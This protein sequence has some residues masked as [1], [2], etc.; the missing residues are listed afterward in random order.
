[1]KQ[2]QFQY[3]NLHQ[4]RSELRKIQQWRA[5]RITS[6][7]SIQVFSEKLDHQMVDEICG[8]ISDTIP[9]AQYMGCSTNG[10]ICN[11]E[12]SKAPVSIACTVY[13]FP[14]TRIEVLQYPLSDETAKEAA[15]DLCQ[16]V[17]K[18]PWVKAVEM[19]VTIRGMSMTVLCE[20]L[21][22]MRGDVAIFGGGA[23]ADDLDEQAACVFSS[24]G[25]YSEHGVTFLLIGG[26]DFFVETT[27]VAGWKPLGRTFRVT[28]ASR[29]VLYEL[30]GSPAYEVYYN[31]LNI[32]NDSHFFI[33]SLEFPFFCEHNGIQILRAPTASGPDGSLT[34]TSDI[35]EGVCANLAY[36]DPWTILEEIR[37]SCGSIS[38][39]SPEVIHLYSCAARR[40]FW[41]NAEI[42]R[43]S[44]PFQNL[45]STAGFYTSGEFL[46]TNGKMN[47][48]NVTL[49][50][51][52]MREGE[53]A[54][55][56]NDT[57]V[58]S[59]KNDYSGKVSMINRLATFIGA[60]TRELEEANERL[61]LAAITDG[62]TQLLNRAEIQRRITERLE[63]GEQLSLIMLDLDNFKRVNDTYGHQ[64][65]DRVILGLADLLRASVAKYPEASAGRWGGE[66]FMLMLPWAVDSAEKAA[67]CLHTKFRELEFPAAGHQTLSLGVTQ[68]RAEDSSDDLLVRVDK[69]LY[70]AKET[71]KDRYVIL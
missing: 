17:A 20:E 57:A 27:Y 11:G 38:Q 12:I 70:E 49:V 13:E 30:D 10:S 52:A 54:E 68:A 24:A 25:A 6:C 65:G 48:H 46:R 60:A 42:S 63:S 8:V 14:T 56:P 53:A 1:M 18:N 64:E 26:S 59:V 5:T 58:E 33:N 45:A 4:L 22:K 35:D 2:F 28:R 61:E 19:F 43:E 67:N 62:M 9:D 41:G 32:R 7:V 51:A 36:G 23:F 31:Y 21:Q 37:Q 44:M 40:T 71:G 47:Q 39:F 50:V 16:R 15:E 66:E 29:N 3:S 69:A 55:L 34:M